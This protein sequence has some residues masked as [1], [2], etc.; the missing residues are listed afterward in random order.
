MLSL[1]DHTRF[2]L[3][4]FLLDIHFISNYVYGCTSLCM[5]VLM[6]ASASESQR[7]P[8]PRAGVIGSCDLSDVGA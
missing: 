4:C 7:H 8:I 1:S 5:Y 6:G 2:N 3:L